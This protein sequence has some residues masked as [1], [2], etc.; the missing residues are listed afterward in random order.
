MKRRKKKDKRKRRKGEEGGI[1][2]KLKKKAKKK[3]K[4]IGWCVSSWRQIPV[5]DSVEGRKAM[6]RDIPHG[7]VMSL[8]L[9]VK[10]SMGRGSYRER[11]HSPAPDVTLAGGGEEGTISQAAKPPGEMCK[12]NRPPKCTKCAKEGKHS[13]G[14][15]ALAV[16]NGSARF[17]PL[18]R[19]KTLV[20]I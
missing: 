8:F 11:R 13:T 1:K 20:I 10:P 17:G 7:E 14:N 15:A 12:F 18:I 9:C 6:V 16:V 4:E 5:C 3:V 2:E 19:S